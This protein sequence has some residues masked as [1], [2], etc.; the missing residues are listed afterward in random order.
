MVA[1][2]SILSMRNLS[3]RAG[4][5]FPLV[6]CWK[7]VAGYLDSQDVPITSNVARRGLIQHS[8][9]TGVLSR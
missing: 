7:R 4:G 6:G 5:E 9:C 2:V 8:S 1:L 3:S